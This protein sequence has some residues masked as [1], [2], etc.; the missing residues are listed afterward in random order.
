MALGA[1]LA[2]TAWAAFLYARQLEPFWPRLRRVALELRD[3]PAA[4]DGLTILHVTDPHVKPRDPLGQ[5]LIRRLASV[6]ADLVCMTGDYGEI[7]LY[8]AR[9]AEALAG[10]RGRLGTYAVLGN[11]DYY[12]CDGRRP[13]RFLESTA[14]GVAARLEARGIPVLRNEAVR[15]EVGG[16]PLWIVGLDDTHTFHGDVARAYRDVPNNET[17]IVLAH[18]WEAGPPAAERGARLYLCGHSH[19]GKVRGPFLPAPLTNSHRRPPKPSGLFWLGRT[20]VYISPGL[21]GQHQL[22]FL[23]RPE[24][25]LFSLR[26]AGGSGQTAAGR[27]TSGRPG[28]AP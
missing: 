15:L 20:A 3:L 14:R 8:A 17:A 7:P 1:G 16:T 2:A 24:A 5:L 13:S 6:E 9:A 26:K 25:T 23:V 19:G 18:T 10:V 11:H 21:S 4:L 28:A 12:T 22:R 27:A